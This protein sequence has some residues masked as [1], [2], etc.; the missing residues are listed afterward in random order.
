MIIEFFKIFHIQ[1]SQKFPFRGLT[2]RA[3]QIEMYFP[4]FA[5]YSNRLLVFF[6]IQNKINRTPKRQKKSNIKVSLSI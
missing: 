4:G 6:N 2:S 1:M 3:S 5:K